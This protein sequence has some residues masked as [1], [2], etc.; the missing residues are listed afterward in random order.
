MSDVD[1]SDVQ[2]RIAVALEKL[3]DRGERHHDAFCE[4]CK[5][6]CV[7]CDKSLPVLPELPEV[8]KKAIKRLVDASPIP[9]LTVMEKLQEEFEAISREQGYEQCTHG[10]W[11]DQKF[12]DTNPHRRRKAKTDD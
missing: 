3:V 6:R 7:S 12:L 2:L 11:V 4:R 1:E 9:Y 5:N 8:W 10:L